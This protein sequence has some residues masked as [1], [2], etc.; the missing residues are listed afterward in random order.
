MKYY[1]TMGKYE[2]KA[3]ARR[4]QAQYG[5]A[6]RRELRALGI[7]AEVERARVA[8]GE[9]D[10][11]TPGVVRVVAAPGTPEQKLMIGII[12]AGYDAVASHQSAAWLWDLM[13]PP[14]RNAVTVRRGNGRRIPLVAVHRLGD[15][16]AV[17]MRRNIPC[18]NPLRTLV[19]LAA[20][21]EHGIVIDAVDRALARKL[22]T[23]EGLEAEIRRLS[24]PG[25]R[26]VGVL[27]TVLVQQGMISGPP[28]SVL[29][30]RTLRLLRQGGMEPLSRE[31]RFGPDNCYRIDL[32][33]DLMVAMEVDGYTYHRSAEA[34]A[35]D[36]RRRN[37]IRLSGIFLLVYD[38][39]SITR[40]GRRVLAECR[41]ALARYGSRGARLSG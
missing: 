3:V 38:W 15:P 32:M 41:Q 5:V 11:P 2:T 18:T 17:S 31:V 29:E 25:R 40:D 24:R 6:G 9:W 28:A 21:A 20:V 26:G 35:N 30:S 23:V 16:P 39:I 7:T 13:A 19:D 36:E 12:E 27:R 14:D 37:E 1:V 10:R 8:S 34:K 4:F 33:L 22:V